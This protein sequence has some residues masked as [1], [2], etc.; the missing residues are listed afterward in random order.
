[1]ANNKDKV[2]I[3]IV[4]FLFFIF[5]LK[6]RVKKFANI[7]IHSQIILKSNLQSEN[8]HSKPAQK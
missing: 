3:L 8:S 7:I 5:F 2:K 6:K 1:M 4:S